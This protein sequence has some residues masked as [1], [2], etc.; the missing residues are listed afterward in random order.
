[1]SEENEDQRQDTVDEIEEGAQH[2]WAPFQFEVGPA[3]IKERYSTA[4][5]A[6]QAVFALLGDPP[7][8]PDIRLAD[9]HSMKD[10]KEKLLQYTAW[11]A[12][13]EVA[14]AQL[15]N[16]IADLK[17]ITVAV[18]A[19]IRRGKG[20]ESDKV[21]E[22]FVQ[23]DVRYIQVNSALSAAE[24]RL[25]LMSA[26]KNAVAKKYQGASR[27]IEAAKTKAKEVR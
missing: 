25:R 10:V 24:G 6:D 11:I 13:L 27:S 15:E 12:Y 4:D 7:S 16:Q 19:S 3:T 14:I 20:D 21:K 23:T 2:T 22:D 9:V 8:K 17:K 26:T 1:M 18:R 5:D